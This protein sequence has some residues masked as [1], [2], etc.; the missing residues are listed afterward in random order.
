MSI[1]IRSGSACGAAAFG[2]RPTAASP[3]IRCSTASAYR[4][5]V[6]S[7][8]RQAMATSSGS[9]P[10]TTRMR[11]AR[12]RASGVFKTIDGG[13]HWSAMG[14]EDSHHIARIVIRSA[15]SE[16]RLRRGDGPSLLDERE[17]GVFRTMDGGKTWKK[18]LYVDDHTGA[19]DL[20]IDP[21][22]PRRLYA[23]M[24]DKQR[25]P[26]RSD[27]ERAGE[28]HLPH[29][30]T[31]ATLGRSC[32][33]SPDRTARPHRSR[34]LSQESAHSVRARSRIRIRRPSGTRNHRERDVSHRRRRREL[35]PH[36]RHERRGR[37]GAVLV[38]PDSRRSVERQTDHRQQRQ[39]DDQRGRRKNVGR[40]KGVADGILPP[41]VRRFP[42][43]VVRSRRPEAH[44]A[45][46]RRRTCRS[47]STADTRRISFRICE[48]ARRTPSASTWTIR[49][50]CTPA[51]RIT[52][53]GRDRSTAAGARSCSRTG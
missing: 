25:L 17:R 34:H 31:A 24:Y 48:L 33:R 5:S 8:W 28:R 20:V 1:S 23:A 19:I 12:I 18:V 37:E 51:S 29:D 50:T 27:R 41:L 44:P 30:R 6:R 26:W 14:L 52:I 15:Q 4:R 7:P 2:R 47:R 11:A 43:D 39:H 13:K 3:G 22:N 9:G 42:H 21:S 53:R 32:R 36:E 10:A 49:I 40:S 46:Q 45:G 38:Q 35:A 16:H